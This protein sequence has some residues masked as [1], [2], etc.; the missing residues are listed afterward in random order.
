MIFRKTI[1]AAG[2]SNWQTAGSRK[3]PSRAELPSMSPATRDRGHSCRHK[4]RSQHI[5]L[6]IFKFSE[7]R[8]GYR[9]AMQ[10]K[11]N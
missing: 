2:Q 1:V 9:D 8:S 11:K 5:V 10:Q 3:N 7:Q 4:R 6:P